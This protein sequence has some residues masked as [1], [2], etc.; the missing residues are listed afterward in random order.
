MWPFDGELSAAY[1]DTADW[2]QAKGQVAHDY[3]ERQLAASDGGIVPLTTAIILKSLADAGGGAGDILRAGDGTAEAVRQY[4]DGAPLMSKEVLGSVL[5]DVGRAGGIALTVGG[6]GARGGTP[7]PVPKADGPPPPP[8]PPPPPEGTP[9]PAPNAPPPPPPPA[10]PTT[11]ATSGAPFQEA[12]GLRDELSGRM[13]NLPRAQQPLTVTGGY[14]PVTGE[15]ASGAPP[16]TGCAETAVE[17]ALGVGPGQ[18]KFTP[19]IRP[20]NGKEVPV[21]PKCEERYGRD[22]F[23]P[24]TT[25]RT[26]LTP[27][28]Q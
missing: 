27:P 6:V 22:A 7:K 26:D 28:A 21:C 10:N 11:A 17:R 23:P 16:G 13:G 4:N 9:A 15:A 3:Y 18:L 20:R 2:L 12:I 19:A 1:H 24:G 8:P 25:F 5:Q 14:N